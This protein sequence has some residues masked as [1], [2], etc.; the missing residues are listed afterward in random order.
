MSCT[1]QGRSS[2]QSGESGSSST[3]AQLGSSRQAWTTRISPSMVD[4]LTQLGTTSSH[5]PWCCASRTFAGDLFRANDVGITWVEWQR[6]LR[7]TAGEVSLADP[8]EL[9]GV[10]F[11]N[12]P[13]GGLFRPV[14]LPLLPG[15]LCGSQRATATS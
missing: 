3:S 10:P 8:D 15:T 2:G 6:L 5:L 13:G 11:S 14:L 12:M 7:P 9:H 1:R 4:S